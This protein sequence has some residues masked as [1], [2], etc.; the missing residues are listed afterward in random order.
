M[1][2]RKL[3]HPLLAEMKEYRNC[4][5]SPRKYARETVLVLTRLWKTARRN[6]T[7]V[8]GLVTKYA[9]ATDN[10]KFNGSTIKTAFR[11]FLVKKQGGRCCYCRCWLLAASGARHIEHVLPRKFYPGF[12]LDFLNLSV[13]CVDCNLAKTKDVWGTI[14]VDAKAYPDAQHFPDM[15]HPRF[16]RYDDHVRYVVFE[17]NLGGIALYR[18]I[19]PQGQHLCLHLLDKIASKR[20]LLNNNLDLKE[21]INEIEG[22]RN[23]TGHIDMPALDTFSQALNDRLAEL[24][25]E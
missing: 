8:W 3:K 9:H 5:H 7:D 6:N 15:Y 23:V 10:E 2:L 11:S 1:S 19:T 16:H 12:S 20:A 24:I 17:S 4:A 13:A 18:G 25:N 21:S 14:S 22:Y